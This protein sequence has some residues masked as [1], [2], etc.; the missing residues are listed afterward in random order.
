MAVN[1]YFVYMWYLYSC[2]GMDYQERGMQAKCDPSDE[3]DQPVDE[4]YMQK[5]RK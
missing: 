4:F 1:I 2:L 3:R 5:V